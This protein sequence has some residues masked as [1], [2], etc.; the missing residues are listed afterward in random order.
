[1]FKNPGKKRGGAETELFPGPPKAGGKKAILSVQ[2]GFCEISEALE[3]DAGLLNSPGVPDQQFD[4]H[5]L[6]LEELR[7]RV[8]VTVVDAAPTSGAAIISTSV[9]AGPIYV[10]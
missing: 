5:S 2:T 4:D 9:R 10:L 3:N 8:S 7:V 1:V 6:V